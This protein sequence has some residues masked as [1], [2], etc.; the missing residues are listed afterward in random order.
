MV[1][2]NNFSVNKQIVYIL[3]TS[4]PTI[5]V[6][7]VPPTEESYAECAPAIGYILARGYRISSSSTPDT[8]MSTY[9]FTKQNYNWGIRR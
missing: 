8:S 7:P 2:A 4:D 6:G 5:N 3:S 9:F 1:C